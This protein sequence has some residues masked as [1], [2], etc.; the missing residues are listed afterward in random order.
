MRGKDELTVARFSAFRK[1]INIQ[2]YFSPIRLLT[3]S[4]TDDMLF[5]YPR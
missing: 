1:T 3:V 2:T 5:C 4:Q